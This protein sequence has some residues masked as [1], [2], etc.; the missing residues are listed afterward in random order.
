[1]RVKVLEKN[2]RSI[3]VLIE[4]ISL[5]IINAIRRYAMTQVP[6]MAIDEVLVMVNTS[7]LF[8]EIL[9]HRLG[10]I[11]LK[12]D[13]ALEKYRSPEE[14]AECT[15]YARGCENCF[16]YLRLEA[17]AEGESV[18]VYSGDIVSDDPDIT[19][20]YK[21]IPI[22]TLAPGQRLVVEMRARLGR[23]IEHIKWSPVTVATNRY[24][25]KINV[26]RSRCDLCKRCIELCP[27]KIFYIENNE[28]KVRNEMNCILCKQCERSCPKDAIMLSW[29]ED[30]YILRLE[31]TGVLKPERILSESISMLIKKLD[32]LHEQM[33]KVTVK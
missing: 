26:D 23:G 30:K 28:L 25:A 32:E 15:A 21:N 33:N 29:Y 1:M 8:D 6:T 20:V 22:V 5:P 10:L 7:P 9:A 19:P 11:P 16:A 12:S 24:V 2:E 18:T 4:G 27:R 31:S 13:E 17:A 14:C 3:E